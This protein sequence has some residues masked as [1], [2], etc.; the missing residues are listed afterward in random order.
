MNIISATGVPVL[1]LILLAPSIGRKSEH[2]LEF[3]AQG[4]NDDGIFITL[5]PQN[6]AVIGQ[7]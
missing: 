1:Y 4:S 3:V 6:C 5:L 2:L 7:L